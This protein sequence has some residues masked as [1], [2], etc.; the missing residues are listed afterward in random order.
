MGACWNKDPAKRPTLLTVGKILAKPVEELGAYGAAEGAAAAAAAAAKQQQLQPVL[1]G[2]AAKKPAAP[3]VDLVA[4]L[5]APAEA[6]R[7][8]DLMGKIG[9]LL[10]STDRGQQLRGLRVTF[11]LCEKKEYAQYM[12]DMKVLVPYIIECMGPSVLDQ[13]QRDLAV[14]VCTKLVATPECA[15]EF[16]AENGWATLV[17]LLRARDTALTLSGSLCMTVLL[18]NA[19]NRDNFPKVEGGLDVLLSLLCSDNDSA[20]MNAVW[21]ASLALENVQTQD[22]FVSAGGMPMILRLAQNP[23]PGVVLRVLVTVGLLLTNRAVFHDLKDSGVV[24][25]FVRLLA[26]PSAMLQQNGAE[27]MVRFSEVPELR[28]LLVRANALGAL[29]ELLGSTNSVLLKRLAVTVFTNFLDTEADAVHLEEAQAMRPV[30]R[31]MVSSDSELRLEALRF[32]SKAASLPSLR[33]SMHSMGALA[34]LVQL[35][36]TKD[37]QLRTAALYTLCVASEDEAVSAA[38]VEADAAAQLMRVCQALP[39]DRDVLELTT[40]TFGN[41]ARFGEGIGALR[42]SGAFPMLVKL[43]N[44]PTLSAADGAITA[45]VF[46][47]ATDEGRVTIAALDGVAPL[48]RLM[49]TTTDPERKEKILWSCPNWCQGTTADT[50]VSEA[51]P[52]LVDLLNSDNDSAQSVCIKS[53]LL[54]ASNPT[55]RPALKKARA[56]EALRVLE[57]TTDNPTLKGG[58]ESAAEVSCFLQM[59]DSTLYSCEP[60]GAEYVGLSKGCMVPVVSFFFFGHPFHSDAPLQAKSLPRR[61]GSESCSGAGC[62]CPLT[63]LSG[64]H[65][66]SSGR[67]G[68]SC[69]TR[70]RRGVPSWSRTCNERG[71][72]LPKCDCWMLSPLAR[73]RCGQDF[74]PCWARLVSSPAFDPVVRKRDSVVAKTTKTK[75]TGLFVFLVA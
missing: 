64:R 50:V 19:A 73:G 60:E 5:N 47:S 25:R 32:L 16:L 56:A 65:S 28:D 63:T 23:N 67:G 37:K 66:H 33:L 68:S 71:R 42:E 51:L 62:L 18:K 21:S 41:F 26:S 13:Q 22:L 1:Q 39:D 69:T 3:A 40:E 74:V 55:Y 44:P 54:L 35:L 17:E 27:A 75:R 6:E 30:V 57:R 36:N 45:L 7:T 46:A 34:P 52:T 10:R 70:A 9:K 59:T 14:Q 53:V 43:V 31:L 61:R 48:L 2:P 15:E 38:F 20:R 58:S 49:A 11:N 24:P 29:L 4:A 12:A 8:E 72:S